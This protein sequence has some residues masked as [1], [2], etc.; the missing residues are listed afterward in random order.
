M[1]CSTSW[2]YHSILQTIF[3]NNSFFSLCFPFG[4][5]TFTFIL[6]ILHHS[7]QIQTFE[8]YHTLLTN[9]CPLNHWFRSHRYHLCMFLNPIQCPHISHSYPHTYHTIPSHPSIISSSAIIGVRSS[10]RYLFHPLLLSYSSSSLYHQGT[11][12]FSFAI[13][14]I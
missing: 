5:S 14:V 1:R 8:P 13:C 4:L 9:N 7:T 10:P 6:G 3:T 11:A 12:C 2:A